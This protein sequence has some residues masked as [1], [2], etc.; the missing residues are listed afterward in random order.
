MNGRH[1]L[2]VL[3]MIL[4]DKEASLLSNNVWLTIIIFDWNKRG[5]LNKTMQANNTLN[6]VYTYPFSP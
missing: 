5:D 3:F 6:H 2:M 4:G 1:V